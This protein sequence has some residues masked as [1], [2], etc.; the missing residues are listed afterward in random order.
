[1]GGAVR[2]QAWEEVIGIYGFEVGIENGN[3]GE[4]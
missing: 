4:G 3:S 2:G 1:M